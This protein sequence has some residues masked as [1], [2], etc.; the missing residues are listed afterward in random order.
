[1]PRGVNQLYQ[2]EPRA[3][4]NPL[5]VDGT[6][7]RVNAP[8]EFVVFL[9]LMRAVPAPTGAAFLREAGL[10]LYQLTYPIDINV[11]YTTLF[12]APNV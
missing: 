10:R 7:R 11:Y 3:A 5:R 6:A 8:F 12:R 4:A 2:K 1:M 9:T